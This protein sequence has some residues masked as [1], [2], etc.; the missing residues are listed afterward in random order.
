MNIRTVKILLSGADGSEQEIDATDKTITLYAKYDGREVVVMP[1]VRAFWLHFGGPG[2]I[3][4][5]VCIEIEDDG[6]IVVRWNDGSGDFKVEHKKDLGNVLLTP[7]HPRK[8]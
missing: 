2:A 4:P 1:D 8:P 5:R 3:A 6:R 7:T